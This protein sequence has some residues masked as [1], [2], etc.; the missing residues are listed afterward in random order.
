LSRHLKVYG[1]QAVE[2]LKAKDGIIQE[3]DAEIEELKKRLATL[4][5]E[6]RCLFSV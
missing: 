4:E 1:V 6:L 3:R 5:K 2:D